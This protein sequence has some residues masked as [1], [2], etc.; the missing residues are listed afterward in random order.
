[1]PNLV[2]A[3]GDQCRDFRGAHFFASPVKPIPG[4]GSPLEAIWAL[5]QLFLRKTHS[6][7]QREFNKL[8]INSK[9]LLK[10]ASYS[11][12]ALSQV[13]SSSVVLLFDQ[14]RKSFASSVSHCSSV[15]IS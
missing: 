2:L 5:Q 15:I 8:G 4:K 1:M 9:S 6:L 7:R 13:F 14:R 12:L 11:I 3:V 10:L